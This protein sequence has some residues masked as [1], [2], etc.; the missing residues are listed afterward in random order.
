MKISAALRH[1]SI[2][3]RTLNCSST[4]WSIR[5]TSRLI[6]PAFAWLTCATGSPVAWWTISTLSIDS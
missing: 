2:S 3:S 1:M 5:L 6:S 4:S